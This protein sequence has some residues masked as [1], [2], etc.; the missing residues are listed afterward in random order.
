MAS[1]YRT[2]GL[3]RET[4]GNTDIGPSGKVYQLKKKFV[5]KK[6][7]SK[8][9]TGVFLGIKALE[10]L[11]KEVKNGG[12]DGLRVCFGQSDNDDLEIV[13][14]PIKFDLSDEAGDYSE[15]ISKKGN[16]YT[17]VGDVQTE[18]PV[19]KCPPLKICK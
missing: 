16:Y 18:P 17:S 4:E 8:R 7:V 3:C 19:A 12:F 14:Q 15:V 11:V 1:S 5:E 10:N 13:A 9:K 6:T 2:Y